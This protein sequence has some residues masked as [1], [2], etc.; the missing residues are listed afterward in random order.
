MTAKWLFRFQRP[1]IVQTTVISFR[2]IFVYRVSFKTTA[3]QYICRAPDVVRGTQRE[4][5][6][7][8]VRH[9]IV[10]RILVFKR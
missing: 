2:Q 8:P 10:K 1:T 5:S 9:S 6:S 3:T 7:K 4:F